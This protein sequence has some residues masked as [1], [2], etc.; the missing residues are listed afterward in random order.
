MIFDQ[1]CSICSFN[2]T[3]QCGKRFL[4]FVQFVENMTKPMDVMLCFIKGGWLK[5][6]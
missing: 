3:Y 6:S 5:P 4:N 1:S 2:E